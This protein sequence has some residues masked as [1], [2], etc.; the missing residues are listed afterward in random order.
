MA[1]I[2]N[3]NAGLWLVDGKKC[4]IV[5]IGWAAEFMQPIV[6]IAHALNI[7]VAKKL[8]EVKNI[9]ELQC[10]FSISGWQGTHDCGGGIS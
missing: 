1:S 5:M 6:V 8:T 4:M 10:R 3:G 2:L 7:K 9:V